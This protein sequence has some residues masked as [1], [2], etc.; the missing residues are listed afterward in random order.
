MRGKQDKIETK[1]REMKNNYR[2]KLGEKGRRKTRSGK[3]VPGGVKQGDIKGPKK[4]Q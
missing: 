2:Q 3:N 4:R 1:Y